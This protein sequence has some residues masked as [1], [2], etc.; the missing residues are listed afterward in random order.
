M[1]RIFDNPKDIAEN[2]NDFF[3]NID[4]NTEKEIPKVLEL[5]LNQRNQFIFLNSAHRKWRIT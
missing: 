4:P 2:V 1:G 3:V 5:F